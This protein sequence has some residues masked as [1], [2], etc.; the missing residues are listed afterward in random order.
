MPTRLKRKQQLSIPSVGQD[1]SK[2]NPHSLFLAKSLGKTTLEICFVISPEAEL[3]RISI[4]QKY[5]HI[6]PKR[7]IQRYSW[8]H[9]SEEPQTGTST[10]I[11]EI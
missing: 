3:S 6:H 1:T 4:Q 10:V 11:D 7:R 5:T 2:G 9:Y 8:W